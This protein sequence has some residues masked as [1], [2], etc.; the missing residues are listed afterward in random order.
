MVV[1]SSLTLKQFLDLDETEPASEY[2]CGEVVQKPMPNRPHAAIQVF[3]GAVL[4]QFL[5]RTGLGRVFTEF[6]CI[7][8]PPNGERTYVPDITYVAGNRLTDDLYLRTAPDL[9][10]E[11]LSPDQ[12]MGRFLDKVQFYLRHG[13]RLLWVIDPIR[14]TITVLMPGEDA[15]VLT[16][17]AVLDGGEVLPG[18]SVPIADIF[19]QTK[20]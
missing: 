11:V 16:A 12:D 14:S 5:S 4:L 19:A 15:R 20:I 8:G 13:V 1:K 7:F 9:A 3:L 2:A 6:R 10:V 18:F 17:E